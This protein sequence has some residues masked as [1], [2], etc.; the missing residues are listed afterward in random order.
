MG[1]IHQSIISDAGPHPPQP[2]HHPEPLQRAGDP[3]PGQAPARGH[4]MPG[5]H[6]GDRPLLPLQGV[7]ATCDQDAVRMEGSFYNQQTQTQS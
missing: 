7:E 3:D 2:H 1:R 4:R 6:A 5:D